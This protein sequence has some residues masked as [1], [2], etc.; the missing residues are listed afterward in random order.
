MSKFNRCGGGV[1]IRYIVTSAAWPGR[2]TFTISRMPLCA[3]FSAALN[4]IFQRQLR[5]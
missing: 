2:F 1:R 5:P 3:G 4:D